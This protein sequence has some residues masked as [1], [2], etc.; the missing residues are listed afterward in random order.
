MTVFRAAT[1]GTF[2]FAFHAGAKELKKKLRFLFDVVVV[3]CSSCFFRKAYFINE[4]QHILPR[5]TS[6]NFTNHAEKQM[7]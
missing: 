2:F 4:R 1:L 7:G 6:T 3:E 5:V